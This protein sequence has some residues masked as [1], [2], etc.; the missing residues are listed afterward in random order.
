MNQRFR[1]PTRSYQSRSVDGQRSMTSTASSVHGLPA[2]NVLERLGHPNHVERQSDGR[3]RW[4]Y[5]WPSAAAVYFRGGLV[6][7]TFYTAGY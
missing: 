5:S 6:T 1:N 3:A 2:A 4:D 7:G